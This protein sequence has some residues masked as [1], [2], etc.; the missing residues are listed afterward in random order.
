[1][2]IQESLRLYTPAFFVTREAVETVALKN[3][4]IPKGAIL[5]IPIPFIHEDPNVWG[6]VAHKF[7][8]KDILM[9]LLSLPVSAGL[10]AIRNRSSYL[11]WPTLSNDTTLFVCFTSISAFTCF[12]WLLNLS[13]VL[14]S[15]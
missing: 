9:E 5:Q 14:F 8:P 7:N 12:T 4:V 11:C 13:M 3:I 1:M 10:R 6:A 2:V 15:M